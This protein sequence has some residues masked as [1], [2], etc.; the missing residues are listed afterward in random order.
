MAE[1]AYVGY[2][3]ETFTYAMN[4]HPDPLSYQP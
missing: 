2:E 3:Y 4:S 1:A